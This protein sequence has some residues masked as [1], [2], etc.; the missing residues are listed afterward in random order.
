MRVLRNTG[1]TARTH[2]YV[3]PHPGLFAPF[4]HQR[5]SIDFLATN[6]R[7][8]DLSD[9]G[10]G[11]TAASIWAAEYLLQL[12]LIKRVLVLA[13][14]STMESVWF[15][16]LFK[17]TPHRSRSLVTG[18][19]ARKG[20]KLRENSVWVI[21]N[22]DMVKTKGFNTYLEECGHTF[23]LIIVDEASVLRNSK[24]A[25][26]KATYELSRPIG[27]SDPR[28]WLLTGTP[29][30]QGPE[31]AY[32]LARLMDESNVP[33]SPE[34]WRDQTMLQ[35]AKYKWVP[36]IG[37]WDKVFA[38]LQPA[39]RH[40]FEDCVDI[41]E[42]T[43]LNKY[44]PM[45][46]EQQDLVSEIKNHMAA[47]LENGDQLVA[48]NAGVQL[49]KLLQILQG[50]VKIEGDKILDVDNDPRMD[51]LLETIA[52]A[53]KKFIVLAP[54]TAV[55]HKVNAAI[56]EAGYSTVFVDGSV[57][58]AE[59]ARRFKEV[60]E[61]NAHGLVAQCQTVAHGL[62]LTEAD[63]T[64]WFGPTFSTEHYLQGNRRTARPGQDS[65]TRVV[66]IYSSPFEENVFRAVQ[67][68]AMNQSALL[69]MFKEVSQG[70]L[71]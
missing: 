34:L 6:H 50:A 19:A 32:G 42:T 40:K 18:S 66:N 57:S 39:V 41:P 36:K 67:G 68:N 5:E 1:Y 44:A 35:V 17:L 53:N 61:G 16:E 71:L 27:R 52:E 15:D 43:Y 63:T 30:P 55:L 3:K 12:G 33:P 14:K 4:A 69:E 25:I 70:N 48:V 46:R 7:A 28:L 13:T 20:K 8:L 37:A 26:H 31:D 21:G 2:A 64:I 65:K 54:F 49:L 59:R 11:K 22:H 60:K 9:M 47:T 51:V 62:T 10:C 45:T 24:S 56:Q 23:D 58:D 38:A 29:T